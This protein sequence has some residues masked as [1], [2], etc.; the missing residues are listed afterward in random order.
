MRV[1]LSVVMLAVWLGCGCAGHNSSPPSPGGSSVVRSGNQKLIVTPETAPA[2]K[3]V[4][5]NQAGQFVVLNYPVGHLPALELR[6]GLYRRGFKVG[7]VKIVGPQYDD[8]IVADVL[9]GE[10]APG[11]EARNR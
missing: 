6:L 9:E 8:N 4:K 5:V 1:L 11:D 3:V 2:G 10:A 7:E